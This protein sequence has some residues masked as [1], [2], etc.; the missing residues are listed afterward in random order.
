[1]T[2][3]TEVLHDYFNDSPEKLRKDQLSILRESRLPI[4]A[5]EASWEVHTDPERFSKKFKFK[6][7]NR[8]TDF[9]TV[10]LDHEDKVQ[11]HGEIRISHNE[12]DIDVYTH[13]VNRITELDQEYARSIDF[14]YRDVLDFVYPE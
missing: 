9:V 2:R 12:V 8:L 6:T 1:M 11:H 5:N 10:V 7:R 4:S 14:I 13:N 3:L